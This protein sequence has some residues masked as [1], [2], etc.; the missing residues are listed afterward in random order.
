VSVKIGSLFVFIFGTRVYKFMKKNEKNKKEQQK[1]EQG[2]V[3][4]G[5]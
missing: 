2:K 3:G 5:K 4:K 1:K